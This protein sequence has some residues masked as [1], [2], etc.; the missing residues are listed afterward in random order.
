MYKCC[1]VVEGAPPNIFSD[2]E[3]EE[4]FGK[5]FD[6]TIITIIIIIIKPGRHPDGVY[7]AVIITNPQISSPSAVSVRLM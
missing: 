4:L 5:Q 6:V 3:I 7:A 2:A 1:C